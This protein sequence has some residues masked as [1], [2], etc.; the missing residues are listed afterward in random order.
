MR[1]NKA[2]LLGAS[3]AHREGPILR[4]L[5]LGKPATAALVAIGVWL[6]VLAL[7]QSRLLEIAELKTL[8]HR[9]RQYAD[10]RRASKDLVLVAVDE[11]SL[12]TFGRWPWPRDRFGYVVRYLRD[13][14]AKAI[15]FDI[16]FLEPDE[17]TA[18]FDASF[19]EEV[20]A[21]GNVFFP[22]LL[23]AS[24]ASAPAPSIP[25]SATIPLG[26]ESDRR[27]NV[28]APGL[29]LPIPPLAE[30][31]V[32]LGFI[33]LTSDFDGTT[34]RLKPLAMTSQGALAQLATAVAYDRLNTDRAVI[35]GHTLRLGST[36]IPLTAQGEMIL[37]WH[38]SLDRKP[39]P[40]YS[41]GAVLRSFLEVQKGQR[42][43]L[44]P[45]LFRGKT[46]YVGTTAAGTYD[47]RVTPVSSFTPGVFVQMTALDNILHGRSLQPA[48]A[49][50]FAMTALVVCLATA[51]SFML[52]PRLPAKFGLIVALAA[53]YYGVT[54]WAFTAQALWLE[55]ALP[56]GALGVTFAVAAT[57][58]YL[59][60]G[61]QRRHLR[62]VFDKY[63]AA[64]VVDE[65]LRNPAGVT[66]G[67]EKKELTVLFTDVAGFT[68]ISEALDP[69][70]L[71]ELINRYLSVVT[72]GIL[73]HRGNVNKY[74]GDGIMAVFGAPRGEP[75]HATLACYAALDCQAALA[76][77]REE[78]KAQ[79]YPDMATRIGINSG[80][81][82]VGNM[83]SPAR[84][85]YTVMGDAVNLASRLESANKVY[86]TSI[87]MGPRTYELAREEIQVREVDILRVMGKQKPVVVYELLARRGEMDERNRPVLELYR[88]GLA[89]YKARD[90]GA[91]TQAFEA[92]LQLDPADGPS[93]VHLS[94]AQEYLV[95]P[96]L[97]D[98]AGVYEMRSK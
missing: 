31:A 4:R 54:V 17:G 66:L 86:G 10:P 22:F 88:K 62:G 52:V 58:E 11:A 35:E 27:T 20:R 44:A 48:P 16:L 47:L 89:A 30:A 91:A 13:A 74:L 32:G 45:A 15:V 25:R 92:A 79:G 84:M 90:F 96:P 26:R 3:L 63:M 28:P 33:N 98:W 69:T 18:E 19:A 59:T 75:N 57:W 51:W 8:D 85:E 7:H 39:Y 87:L 21:A 73:R 70:E 24:P 6:A 2:G 78:W 68:S 82:V 46:V 94:R 56:E 12:E 80:S 65:I 55:L 81:L 37:N 95:T 53:V 77:L 83:G 50:V 41:I 64:E 14:E 5:A 42:P 71:V 76:R 36:T 9:F 29:K 34:R 40:A 93:R 23:L 49:W 72:E 61:R 60:E 43:T 1:Y 67:G 97:P 38:G